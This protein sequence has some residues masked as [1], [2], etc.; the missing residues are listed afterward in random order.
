MSAALRPAGRQRGDLSYDRYGIRFAKTDKVYHGSLGRINADE[1]PDV[2]ESVLM[3]SE[4]NN[5]WS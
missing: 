4:T 3:L 2:S 5:L 1:L